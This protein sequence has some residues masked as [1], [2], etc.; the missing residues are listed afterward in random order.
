MCAYIYIYIYIY[1]Y[2]HTHTHTHTHIY[3][4]THT[5]T[6]IHTH[7]HT[8]THS[9][10]VYFD[11]L[12]HKENWSDAEKYIKF[13]DCITPLYRHFVYGGPITVRLFRG[14]RRKAPRMLDHHT[15]WGDTVQLHGGH[16][17][18]AVQENSKV[19]LHGKLNGTHRDVVG[20]PNTFL[21]WRKLISNNDL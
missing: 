15:G 12:L 11:Q 3:T 18:L 19:P 20:I 14:R 8:R 2:T 21:N 13:F 7:T 9:S 4:H 5:H 10:T 17:R 6:H 16:Y 1:I